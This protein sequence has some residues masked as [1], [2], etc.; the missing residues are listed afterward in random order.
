M[1]LAIASP[2]AE[3]VEFVLR[4]KYHSCGGIT[5]P[6]TIEFRP[7]GMLIAHVVPYIYSI[8]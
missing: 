7:M 3:H 5:M 6:M 8:D 2:T 1:A 4:T